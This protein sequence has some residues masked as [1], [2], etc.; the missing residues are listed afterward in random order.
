M[1][2]RVAL[3]GNDVKVWIKVEGCKKT[4]DGMVNKVENWEKYADKDTVII[5]DH[6]K[7][8]NIGQELIDGGYQV[9]N[10]SKY[11]DKIELDREL[12]H[13][14][15]QENGVKTPEFQEFNNWPTAISFLIKNKKKRYVFKPSGNMELDWSYIGKDTE[16]LIE[17][18]EHKFKPEWPSGKPIKFIFEE[19][20]K[21]IEV[22]S[23]IWISRG[24]ILNMNSTMEEKKLLTGNLGPSIGCAGNIVWNYQQAPP[25]IEKTLIKLKDALTK[26]NYCGVLDINT[27]VSEEDDEPYGIEFTSRFGY[28]ALQ[29]WVETIKGDIGEMLYNVVQGKPIHTD[30]SFACAVRVNI[31]PFPFDKAEKRAGD[32]IRFDMDLL[33]SGHYWFFDC[34]KKDKNLQVIGVDGIM[35]VVSSKANTIE[36]AIEKCYKNIEAIESPRDIMYRT[37]IGERVIKEYKTLQRVGLL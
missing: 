18:I 29:A 23:E 1:A 21:G 34:E 9:I 8:S 7:M 15:M 31:P 13:T 17:R 16:D 10:G 26:E 19:F 32:L 30:N 5:I 3:E 24:N 27:I 20:I 25:L 12:G 36:R 11:Q 35:C 2:R 14:L 33:N 22:S 28:D 6:V 37:D 4:L